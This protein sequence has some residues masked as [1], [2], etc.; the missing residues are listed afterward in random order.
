MRRFGFVFALRFWFVFWIVALSIGLLPLPPVAEL[1]ILVGFLTHVA[2][3]V[4]GC[5]H[6]MALRVA[7]ARTERFE[8]QEHRR[9]RRRSSSDL[10]SQDQRARGELTW[11]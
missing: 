8:E 6:R 11:H 2:W 9:Q 1:V 5:F 4:M 10:P 7:L 3:F